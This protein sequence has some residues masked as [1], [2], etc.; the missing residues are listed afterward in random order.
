MH[1]AVNRHTAAELIVERANVEK[2]H[3]GLTT[4]YGRLG[5]AVRWFS[6]I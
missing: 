1:W 5:K 6:G 3:M 4:E 2:E